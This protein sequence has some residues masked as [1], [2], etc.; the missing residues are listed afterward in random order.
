VKLIP[1]KIG[2]IEVRQVTRADLDLFYTEVK[3][4]TVTGFVAYLD[5]TPVA[6]GGLAFAGGLVIAFLDIRNEARPYKLHLM[7]KM[8][9][10]M[11]RAKEMHRVI[12]AIPAE[13]EPT[14]HKLLK[15][16]GFSPPE[17]YDGGWVW[18]RESGN[19]GTG[20]SGRGGRQHHRD[21][22]RCAAGTV[23]GRDGGLSGGRAEKGR[24]RRKG[25]RRAKGRRAA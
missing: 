25:R 8:K 13:D 5:G 7:A 15:T 17:D 20:S 21:A 12:F 23:A 14:S 18:M 4:P 16:M 9:S 24:K 11:D 10:F 2:R 6:L 1:E 3:Y 19:G 22:R